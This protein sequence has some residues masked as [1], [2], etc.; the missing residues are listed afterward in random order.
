MQQLIEQSVASRA[1][2]IQLAP[3]AGNLLDVVLS[4]QRQQELLN[5]I[6]K[7]AAALLEENRPAIEAKIGQELPW[8]LPHHSLTPAIYQ[9]IA[10]ALEPHGGRS[11]GQPEHP[12][13]RKFEALVDRFWPI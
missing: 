3:L 4:G 2:K 8:W 6:L 7:L 13:A 5:G 10:K 9:K 12:A 1:R 11:P